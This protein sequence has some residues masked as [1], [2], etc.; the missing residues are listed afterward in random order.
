MTYLGSPASIK[1]GRLFETKHVLE[2]WSY[3]L[4]MYT[5]VPSKLRGCIN[6]VT[7]QF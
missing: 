3:A 7:Q 1:D 5:N 2:H 4:T 6:C